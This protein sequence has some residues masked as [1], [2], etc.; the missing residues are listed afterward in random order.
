MSCCSGPTIA[1]DVVLQNVLGTDYIYLDE[2]S[3]ELELDHHDDSPT[4][5]ASELRA[6]SPV[7]CSETVLP[8]DYGFF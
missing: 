3:I 4:C 7:D 6:S 2:A 5:Q 1:D 8:L